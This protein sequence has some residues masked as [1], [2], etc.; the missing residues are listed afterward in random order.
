MAL[1]WVAEAFNTALEF[2]ADEISLE[3]RDRIGRAKDLGSAAVLVAALAA[4]VIGA[5]VF[6]PH[7]IALAR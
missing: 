5:L 2:L 4:A 3:H 6:V 7:V 1:V